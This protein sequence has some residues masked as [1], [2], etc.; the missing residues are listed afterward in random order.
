MG[1]LTIALAESDE[2]IE[3]CQ[4]VM[5]GLRPQYGAAELLARVRLQEREGYRLAVLREDRI[6]VALAGYRIGHNLAWG[7]YL[8]VDDLVTDGERRSRGHG[9]RLMDWLM[10]EAAR[11]SC[12]E[13]HL[14]SGVQRFAAH[15]FY[16]RYGLDITS[17][18]FR[19]QLGTTSAS[20]R[21]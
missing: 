5:A 9:R 3:A 14:D 15:R 18:H 7:K 4:P 6:V 8:Y 1:A 2:E 10:D 17:H 19:V 11:Q 13:L 12:D 16:L 21:R 20:A